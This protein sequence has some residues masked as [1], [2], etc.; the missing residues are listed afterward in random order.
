[1]SLAQISPT[2]D[3]FEH[4]DWQGILDSTDERTCDVY[5]R[6]YAEKAREAEEGGD[7]AGCQVLELMYHVCS[8]V[9]NPDS[10]TEP[11]GRLFNFGPDWRGVSVDDFQDCHLVTLGAVVQGMADPEVRARVADILWYHRRGGHQMAGLA[12]SSYLQSAHVLE[13]PENWYLCAYRIERALALAASLGRNNQPFKDVI[14]HIERVLDKCQGEDPLF[15]SEYLM[16]MLLQHGQGDP[17]KYAP[18]A[19][20]AAL[21]AENEEGG[22]KWHKARTYWTI[23]ARWHGVQGDDESARQSQ[24]RA[25]ETFVKEAEDRLAQ[26]P[27]AYSVAASLIQQGIEYLRKVSDTKRR[28]EELHQRLL[29]YQKKSAEQFKSYSLSMD[30]TDAAREAAERVKGRPLPDALFA[31]ALM[32]LSPSVDKLRKRVK[33]FSKKYGLTYIFPM[34]QLSEDGRVVGRRPSLYGDTEDAEQALRAEMFKEARN[35][36]GLIAHAVIQ[37]AL[38]QIQREHAVRV[39]D[40]LTLVQY[41]PFVPTGR[42]YLYARGL[43]AGLTGDLVTAVHLLCPQVENSVRV[44]LSRRGVVVSGLGEQGVQD[45]HALKTNLSRPELA[46][47][48]GDDMVFDLQGLLVERFGSNLRNRLAHGLMDLD[49]FYS[50]HALYLSWVVLRLCLVPVCAQLY[51][52]PDPSEVEETGD[53]GEHQDSDG[54]AAPD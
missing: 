33:D 24:L 21:L 8:L 11:L 49:E 31:L 47:M 28:R 34:R 29:R 22:I 2:E 44:I 26:G 40:L 27:A 19:E 53:D 46:E 15:L 3:D 23:A 39:S 17:Q 37:P 51:A 16:Q 20:K 10:A 6:L 25:A 42:E 36:Q 38:V 52:A 1:M 45:M 32:P 41:S 30:V 18:L 48:L 12:V 54:E 9:L 5:A 7:A 43:Q 35:D 13:D 4:T 50:T 14:A